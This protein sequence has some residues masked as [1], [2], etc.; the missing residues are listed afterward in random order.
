M[1]HW[2]VTLDGG[3]L[4]FPQIFYF[5][6]QNSNVNQSVDGFWTF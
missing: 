4:P 5:L 2:N 3:I 6:N 1:E